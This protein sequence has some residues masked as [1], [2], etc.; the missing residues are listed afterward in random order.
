[1]HIKKHMSGGTLRTVMAEEIKRVFEKFST[2]D[3]PVEKA[4]LELGIAPRTL[5][6][7]RGP[8][9]KGG[10]IE[11]QGLGGMERLL[12]TKPKTKSKKRSKKKTTK[13]KSGHSAEARA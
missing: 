10:W 5:R 13:K 8:V 9:D 2:E 4:S 7:W 1:M 12:G 11:L 6:V 3:M